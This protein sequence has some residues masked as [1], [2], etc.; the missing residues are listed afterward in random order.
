MIRQLEF[1]AWTVS[2]ALEALLIVR[3]LIWRL[4]LP[5]FLVFLC[6]DLA[7]SVLMWY[8]NWTDAPYAL[9]W[10]VTEVP[11]IALLAAAGLEAWS[12]LSK[13]RVD[14]RHYSLIIGGLL[15]AGFLVPRTP[16]SLS[17]LMVPRTFA[18]FAI[19][20]GLVSA[21]GACA[22]C[23]VHAA[24]MAAFCACD[25]TAHLT[26]L[27]GAARF[28]P[29]AFLMVSQAVCLVAWIFSVP[30]ISSEP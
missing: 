25:V 12:R 6:Y 23:S 9:W 5:L 26:I 29:E 1:W 10:R 30:A 22:R 20:A 16:V 8:V 15:V 18:V 28:E 27:L 19:A 24:I 4:R 14:W 3:A 13:L 7:R 21:M 2:L 17:V 11:S